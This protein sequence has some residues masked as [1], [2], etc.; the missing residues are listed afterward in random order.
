MDCSVAHPR[1]RID[2]IIPV[3]VLGAQRD[4]GFTPD[5]AQGSPQLMADVCEQMSSIGIGL[6][7]LLKRRFKLRVARAHL[8]LKGVAGFRKL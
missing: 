8:L 4:V 2:E 7:E 3:V 1:Y 6:A 5:N